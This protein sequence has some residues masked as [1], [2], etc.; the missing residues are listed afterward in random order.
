[1]AG[2]SLMPLGLW[3][4]AGSFA[5]GSIPFGVLIGRFKGVDIRNQG[6]KNIGATNVSRLLGRRLG[7][8]CFALDVAKGVVPVLGAGWILG[9]LGR[10]PA[11]SGP[12]APALNQ[13]EMWLWLGIA[14]A[15]VLGHVFSP[16]LGFRGGKGVATAFGAAIAMWPILTIPALGSLVVWYGVLR[17]SHYVSLSSMV[18]AVSLPVGYALS[19]L[20]R[21]ALDVPASHSLQQI[22]AAS[23]PLLVTTAMAVLVIYKH[24]ANIG[25]LRRGEEPKVRGDAR[26]G[27]MGK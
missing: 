12:G 21:D 5:V 18:A 17:L 19:V 6:S 4:I 7:F 23:P 26:R 20:P 8:M 15:A 1:M 14:C 3:L 27:A 24:R 22:A 13:A 16:L 2:P 10:S 11:V 25:R 9:V